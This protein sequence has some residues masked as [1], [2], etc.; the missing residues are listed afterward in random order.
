MI[1]RVLWAAFIVCLGLCVWQQAESRTTGVKL[2]SVQDRA[3]GAGFTPENFL[4]R[5]TCIWASF[6]NS[7]ADPNDFGTNL[8]TGT[9]AIGTDMVAQNGPAVL[10]SDNCPT[11]TPAAHECPGLDGAD[12]DFTGEDGG[13][14]FNDIEPAGDFSAGIWYYG[15]D[16]TGNQWPWMKRAGNGWGIYLDSGDNF[17]VYVNND[18][19]ISATDYETDIGAENWAHAG[20][21][22]YGSG[23]D[24]ITIYVNGVADCSAPGCT[25]TATGI[26]AISQDLTG[27]SNLST[28]S[29]V[30]GR[31]YEGFFFNEWFT[32]LEWC[33]ICSFG[34]DGQATS[35]NASEC[36]SCSYE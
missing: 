8:C 3:L 6:T 22:W 5:D 4:A 11:G 9:G 28:A 17:K 12:Q 26:T 20:Y 32:A 10:T 31:I 23:D 16:N 1:K 2:S 30:D 24:T 18:N 35:R 29:Y 21:S 34:I 25:T 13:G 15:D 19:E 27:G 36:Q 7:S 14:A 33:E